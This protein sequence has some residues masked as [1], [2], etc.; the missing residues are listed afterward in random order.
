MENIASNDGIP[1]EEEEGMSLE[2][3]EHETEFKFN[4]MKKFATKIGSLSRLELE[5]LLAQKITE[6]IRFRTN[7]ADLR[8]RLERQT[9]INKS[10]MKRLSIVTKQ[11][12][13]FEMVYKRVLKDLNERPDVPI[14]PVKITRDV[15]LQ[16]CD[17]AT[18]QHTRPIKNRL[19]QP[20]PTKDNPQ[21]FKR[22]A[23]ATLSAPLHTIPIKYRIQPQPLICIPHNSK[24]NMQRTK[25]TI[26]ER[27]IY[28]RR[29]SFIQ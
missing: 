2:L 23:T 12:Q 5:E 18:Q 21:N 7:N 10:N 14:V 11:Y 6:S 24:Q 26:S 9:T 13:D 28:P 4:F 15:G 1:D 19:T 25:V 22:P 8:E 27:K 16:V 3:P 17:T 29:F 20:G